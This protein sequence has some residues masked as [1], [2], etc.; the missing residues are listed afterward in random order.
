MGKKWFT[1]L[2]KYAQINIYTVNTFL[3]DKIIDEYQSDSA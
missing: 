2:K 3:K 1:I